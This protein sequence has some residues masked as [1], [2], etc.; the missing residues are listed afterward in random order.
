MPLKKSMLCSAVI[1]EFKSIEEISRKESKSR[2]R[3]LYVHAPGLSILVL[4]WI[5]LDIPAWFT[6]PL[7]KITANLMI[8]FAISLQSSFHKIH[9]VHR[10]NHEKTSNWKKNNN[11]ETDPWL[12]Y[13]QCLSLQGPVVFQ[14]H[15]DPGVEKNTYTWPAVY[16]WSWFAPPCYWCCHMIKLRSNIQFFIL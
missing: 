7:L 9:K 5:I 1:L 3:S 8:A 11:K 14:H 2:T 10:T 12:A 4:H 16:I 13:Q 6:I 15:R